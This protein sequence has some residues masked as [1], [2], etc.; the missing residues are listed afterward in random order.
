MEFFAPLGPS[1]M[2]TTLAP[3][4]GFRPEM[5]STLQL[6]MS[7]MKKEYLHVII[8]IAHLITFEGYMYNLELCT[9]IKEAILV[10]FANK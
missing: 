6:I 8:F 7:A 5:T 3:S 4:T 2:A 9:M 1:T 10:S